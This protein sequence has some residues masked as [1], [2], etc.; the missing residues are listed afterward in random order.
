MRA[1]VGAD[2]TWEDTLRIAREPA[3]RGDSLNNTGGESNN[4]KHTNYLNFFF[5][6]FFF[7][8]VSLGLFNKH[9]GSAE[10][11]HST[12]QVCEQAS[13]SASACCT[14]SKVK[15]ARK[16]LLRVLGS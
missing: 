15:E 10:K 1:A 5:F 16:S 4:S 14:K 6:S 3:P 11:G 9:R 2:L 13:G 8:F 12:A 7:F